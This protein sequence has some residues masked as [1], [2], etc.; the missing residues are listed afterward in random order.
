MQCDIHQK[1]QFSHH[2]G[3]SI[4]LLSSAITEGNELINTANHIPGIVLNS[5]DTPMNKT[6]PY[7][8]RTYAIEK[9]TNKLLSTFLKKSNSPSP[10]PNSTK[11]LY[12][13]W[14]HREKE[15][16]CLYDREL[17][18]SFSNGIWLYI[19][20]FYLGCAH[21]MLSSW[22]REPRLQQQPKLLWW[23][24]PTCTTREGWKL[25]F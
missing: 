24:H 7:I 6:R 23:Q 4:T 20:L 11:P 17:K 5:E 1:L 12:F 18:Q 25:A 3:A 8:R 19:F 21:S 9:C 10:S 2:P 15:L 14:R 13:F 22:A 16:L